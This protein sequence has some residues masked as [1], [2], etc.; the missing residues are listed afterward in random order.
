M[1]ISPR[2][3]GQ[4]AYLQ[5]VLY[6][7]LQWVGFDKSVDVNINNW[8]SELSWKHLIIRRIHNKNQYIEVCILF[9]DSLFPSIFASFKQR[10]KKH[11]LIFSKHVG[12]TDTH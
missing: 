5:F 4:G 11:Q 9:S 1:D 7:Q 2:D 3:A 12:L 6:A 8:F 10:N